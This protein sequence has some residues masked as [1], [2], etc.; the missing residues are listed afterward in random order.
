MVTEFYTKGD[1]VPG[2]ANS[3]SAD[4][5]VKSQTD[6]GYAYQNYT[7]ALLESK[8]CVGWHWFKYMDK[9]KELNLNV[10]NII[11]YFD[12]PKKTTKIYPEADAD[13]KGAENH[14]LTTVWV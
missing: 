12:I 7:L 11:D 4:W 9:M 10:Y 13:F 3:S 2:L 1:D 6:R 5:I 8:Y 14:G